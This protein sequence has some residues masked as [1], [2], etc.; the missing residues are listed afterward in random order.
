MCNHKK[1]SGLLIEHSP[2]SPHFETMLN[3]SNKG[4][5]ESV[6]SFD[7]TLP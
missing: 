4:T 7:V 2:N 1:P 6:P 5:L 3:G